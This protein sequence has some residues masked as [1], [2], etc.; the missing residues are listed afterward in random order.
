MLA[1]RSLAIVLTTGTN[2]GPVALPTGEV[3]PPTGKTI[4]VRSCD[5]VTVENGLATKHNFYYDQT[6]LLSQL[7]LV[8]ANAPARSSF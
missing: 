5:V 7:G 1:H 4:R 8:P 2:T 3:L 6:E